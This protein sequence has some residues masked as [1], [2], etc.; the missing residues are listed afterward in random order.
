MVPACVPEGA[1]WRTRITKLGICESAQGIY[2]KA[3]EAARDSRLP[4]IHNGPQDAARHCI[5]SDED[6]KESQTVLVEGGPAALRMLGE[7]LIAVGD[8]KEHESFYIAP[9]GP[10]NIHFS[11]NA[12]LGIYIHRTDD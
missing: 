11:K 7:L 2:E 3:S 5:G 10:G 12:E 6:T 1:D 4:G 9:F 8:E